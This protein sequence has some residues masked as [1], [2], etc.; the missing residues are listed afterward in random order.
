MIVKMLAILSPWNY[1]YYCYYWELNLDYE[2]IDDCMS[3]NYRGLVTSV[4]MSST[5]VDLNIEK[6][7][8]RNKEIIVGIIDNNVISLE[9]YTILLL[10]DI[11]FGFKHCQK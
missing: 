1:M 4:A 5:L 8:G 9:L 11:E 6:V 2:F 10:L 3:V 7:I